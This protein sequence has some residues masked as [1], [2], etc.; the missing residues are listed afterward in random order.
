VK[1]EQAATAYGV[2]D[3]LRRCASS[4]AP[5]IPWARGAAVCPSLRVQGTLPRAAQA[6]PREPEY[7]LMQHAISTLS[8][9][10]RRGPR[11]APPWSRCR[12]CQRERASSTLISKRTLL[13]SVSS[14]HVPEGRVLCLPRLDY[15]FEALQHFHMP[16]QQT[17]GLYAS[18]TL[19]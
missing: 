11:T 4:M 15:S 2:E 6:L 3:G 9:F 1:L 12:R 19:P 7:H 13:N 8:R 14:E 17:A 10:F 16:G 5:A 18:A